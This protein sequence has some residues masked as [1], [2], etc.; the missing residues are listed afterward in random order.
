MN[1]NFYENNEMEYLEFSEEGDTYIYSARVK[2]TQEEN[3]EG[4]EITIIM[5]LLEGTDF[6]MSFS[7]E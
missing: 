6:V 4:K 2:N 3:S 5:R 1:E 7:M